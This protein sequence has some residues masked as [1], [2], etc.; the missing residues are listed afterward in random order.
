MTPTVSFPR[1][2]IKILLL[3]GIHESAIAVLERHGYSNV[4]RLGHALTG[5]E[6]NAALASAHMVGIRSRTQLDA[7]TL[8]GFAD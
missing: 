6:L 1:E 7:A 4:E 8:A 3:E 5:D 2:K